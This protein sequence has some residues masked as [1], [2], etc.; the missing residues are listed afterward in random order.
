MTMVLAGA[1][2]GG[3]EGSPLYMA[4]CCHEGMGKEPLE[5]TFGY[6]GT[7]SSLLAP[8]SLSSQRDLPLGYR[9][10][11]LIVEYINSR[12]CSW[13]D[14]RRNQILEFGQGT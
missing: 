2:Q 4:Q 7:S 11:W 5:S 10:Y 3:S 13:G 12:G 14:L 8:C 6:T 9:P 1:G